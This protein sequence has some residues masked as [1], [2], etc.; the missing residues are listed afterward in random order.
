MDHG[1]KN[2]QVLVNL[3]LMPDSANAAHTL[4]HRHPR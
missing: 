3:S 4:A 2:S 1:G